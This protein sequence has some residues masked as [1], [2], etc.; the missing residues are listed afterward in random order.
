MSMA[1]AAPE[2]LST[3]PIRRRTRGKVFR[4][5]L[6]LMRPYYAL[7]ALGILLLIGGTPWSLFPALVWKYVTDA[8]DPPGKS[9]PTPILPYLFSFQRPAHW[10]LPGSWSLALLAIRRLRDR[11]GVR[12]DQHQPDEPRPPSGSSS[13]PQP[14]YHKLQGQSSATSSGSAPAT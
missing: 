11:R 7:L 2:T 13:L 1:A 12:H 4:R 14:V 5:L 9:H 6:R 10:D 8:P 3:N